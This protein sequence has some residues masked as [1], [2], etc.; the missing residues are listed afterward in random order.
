MKKSISVTVDE[1]FADP[2]VQR[3]IQLGAKTQP[4][5]ICFPKEINVTR[6]LAWLL[7]PS[8]GHG[9]A[10]LALRSLLTRVGLAVHDNRNIPLPTRRFLASSNVY[11]TGF[12]GVVVA[13]EVNVGRDTRKSLDLFCID[14]RAGF[15]VA[16]ENKFGARESTDQLKTYREGLKSIFPSMLGVHIFLDS[17]EEEPRDQQWI[18]IGYDWLSEFLREH[19]QLETTAPNLRWSLAQFRVAI[20][21]EDAEAASS[22][23]ERLATLVASKHS[24]A[25][26]RMKA[27]ARAK[28]AIPQTLV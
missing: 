10:D 26:V 8:Q 1:F 7:D 25:L 19:E 28:G 17:N 21:D 18:K 20:E 9:M 2:D 24:E 5:Q 11:S 13:T 6:F 15:Y 14:Q 23:V 27:V 22:P 16:L 4:L 3:L 12:S